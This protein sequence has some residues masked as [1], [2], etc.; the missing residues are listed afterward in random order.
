MNVISS[1][2]ARYSGR[3]QRVLLLSA[4]FLCCVL[5]AMS[6]TQ[7]NLN[8]GGTNPLPEGNGKQIVEAVCAQ[9]HGLDRLSRVDE[10]TVRAEFA[11]KDWQVIVNRMVLLG[12]SRKY[13]TNGLRTLKNDEISVVIEYLARNFVGVPRPAAVVI[14]GPVEVSI[15]EWA[16][17]TRSS[18]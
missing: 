17:P 1:S 8:W 7:G 15:H 5:P 18:I 4:G 11:R 3:V 9:C 13:R 16:M 6:Q 14:P 10:W 12:A 2:K